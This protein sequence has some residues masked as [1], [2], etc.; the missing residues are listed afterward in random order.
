MGA[1]L[2]AVRTQRTGLR[3]EICQLDGGD[4]LLIIADVVGMSA[5]GGEPM[6]F[7]GGRLGGFR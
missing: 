1:V 4:H 5:S 2:I 6:V 7:H 3:V